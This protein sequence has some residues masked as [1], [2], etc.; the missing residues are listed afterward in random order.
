MSHGANYSPLFYWPVQHNEKIRLSD[1]GELFEQTWTFRG[2]YL[3]SKQAETHNVSSLSYTHTHH[4]LRYISSCSS[5]DFLHCENN[6]DSLLKT[7]SANKKLLKFQIYFLLWTLLQTWCSPVQTDHSH[8]C[9]FFHLQALT[10]TF[11]SDASLS[12][13]LFF[14]R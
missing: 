12:G 4:S 5:E 14:S 9:C 1:T 10:A 8:F 2:K 13:E 6:S 3:T 7:F 11:P